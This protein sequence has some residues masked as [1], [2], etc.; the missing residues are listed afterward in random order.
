[1]KIEKIKVDGGY[2]SRNPMT[3]TWFV[4]IGE[5]IGAKYMC[6]NKRDAIYTA[7]A[8]GRGEA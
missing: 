5:A 3:G 4:W 1:M 2:I 8:E 6:K 7:K